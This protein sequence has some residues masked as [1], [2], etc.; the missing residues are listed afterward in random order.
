[1]NRDLTENKGTKITLYLKSNLPNGWREASI[2]QWIGRL[3]CFPFDSLK[4]VMDFEGVDQRIPC[5]YFLLGYDDETLKVYIGQTDNFQERMIDHRRQRGEWIENIVIVRTNPELSLTALKYLEHKLF[6]NFDKVKSDLIISENT[7][8]PQL[9]N[10]Q[11]MDQTGYDTIYRN[12]LLLLPVLGYDIFRNDDFINIEREKSSSENILKY[13]EAT[14]YSLP[15]GHFR[16]SKDSIV[17]LEIAEHFKNHSSNKLRERLRQENVIKLING[18][19]IFTES[20]DFKS[21]SAAACVVAGSSVNG[22]LVWQ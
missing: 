2:D 13:K 17:E 20:Y 7:Q 11:K 18:K 15:D 21:K 10:F 5:V 1:M 3:I 8:T 16:V 4:E 19:L 22:N 14:G 6:D 12:I 9:P